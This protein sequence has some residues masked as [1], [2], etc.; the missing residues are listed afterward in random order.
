MR[1]SVILL[2]LIYGSSAHAGFLDDLFKKLN[3]PIQPTQEIHK[4]KS[5]KTTTIRH[6]NAS[7]YNDTG[8]RTASGINTH[9]GVAHKTLPF[10]TKLLVTNPANGKS[11]TATVVDRGPYTPGRTIDVNQNVAEFLDF[12]GI[13]KLLFETQ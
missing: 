6:N 5:I 11:V 13:G 2:L 10:G 8:K 12:K 4:L 1:Y 9:Y 7:W 3:Q